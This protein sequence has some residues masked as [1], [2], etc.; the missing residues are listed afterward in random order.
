MAALSAGVKELVAAVIDVAGN[1]IASYG[2]SPRDAIYHESPRDDMPDALQRWYGPVASEFRKL[3]IPVPPGGRFVL[4]FRALVRGGGVLAKFVQRTPVMFGHLEYGAGPPPAAPPPIVLG[5]LGVMPGLVPLEFRP[6]TPPPALAVTIG[7]PAPHGHVKNVQS[8]DPGRKPKSSFDVVIMG[9]GFHTNQDLREFDT[10][11]NALVHGLRDMQPF[12]SRASTLSFHK[13]TVVS[14]ESGITD[15]TPTGVGKRNTYFYFK[16]DTKTRYV[17]GTPYPQIVMDV[18]GKIAPWTHIDL[19]VVICNLNLDTAHAWRDQRIV[20]CSKSHKE[21][22]H[23]FLVTAAH[24]MGH[25]V[26]GLADEYI[27]CDAYDKV[28]PIPNLATKEDRAAKTEP[29]R[30]IAAR[31]DFIDNNP[32]NDFKVVQLYGDPDPP[33][34]QLLSLGAF[35][36]CEFTSVEDH[37]KSCL[38]NADQRGADFYRPMGRCRMRDMVSDYCPACAAAMAEALDS[39]RLLVVEGKKFHAAKAKTHRSKSAKKKS[40][41]KMV[42]RRAQKKGPKR[43]PAPKKHKAKTK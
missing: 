1:V 28:T 13:I 9:D 25:V 33:D 20:A 23:R 43:S 6:N 32:K 16:T 42:K 14:D 36:G 38:G 7:T 27:C 35:W 34:D 8:L 41:P 22:V 15:E 37:T 24:E 5:G 40:K 17:I 3:Y 30:A 26:A 29:W 39:P 4:L 18:A 2:F 19:V 11:A 21:S 31:S 10:L 12:R